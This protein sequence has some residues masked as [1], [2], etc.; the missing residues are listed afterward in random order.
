M[1]FSNLNM[2]LCIIGV[3]KHHLIIIWCIFSYFSQILN[4]IYGKLK[5]LFVFIF[6]KW[7]WLPFTDIWS[8]AC[9]WFDVNFL[10]RLSDLLEL[11]IAIGPCF[12]TVCPPLT[13]SVLHMEKYYH[14]NVP[15]TWQSL[16]AF[17]EKCLW[18]SGIVLKV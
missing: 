15:S 17:S 3:C 13:L 2:L 9:E 16:S 8:C 10:L 11:S 7:Y 4:L 1:N 12:V 6:L 18:C 14:K 5:S